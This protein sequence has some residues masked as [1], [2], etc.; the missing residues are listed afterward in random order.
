MCEKSLFIIFLTCLAVA[1]AQN[2]STNDDIF[3]SNKCTAVPDLFIQNRTRELQCCQEII[4]DLFISW[5]NQG[6][7]LTRTLA[8][9]KAWNCPEFDEVCSN[10]SLAFTDYTS[11]VYDRFCNESSLIQQCGLVVTEALSEMGKSNNVNRQLDG[12]FFESIVFDM[13]KNSNLKRLS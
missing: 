11:L 12:R 1:T 9:L 8:T 6:A 7:Y 4:E 5:S 10:R 13:K 2:I 3:L